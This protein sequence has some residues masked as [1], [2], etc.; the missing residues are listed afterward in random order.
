[1][2]IK[3]FLV[4]IIIPC[5]NSENWIKETIQSA[6]DQTYN[7]KEIIV[8]DDGST[9]NSLE[10]IK[11]F[12]GNINWYSWDN[13]GGCAAR[14]KGFELSKG[15]F[16]QFLDAD[17][18]LDPRKI[19]LQ[20]ETIGQNSKSIATGPYKILG[21]K[22]NYS[23]Q[24]CGNYRPLTTSLSGID[25]LIKKLETG[26]CWATLPHCF[27]TPRVL[28]EEVGPWDETL[29]INQ[30]GE[31]FSRILIEADTVEFVSESIVYY[32]RQN[33]KSVSRGRNIL[34]AQSALKVCDFYRDRLLE[35]RDI[36]LV[37]SALKQEYLRFIH[38]YYPLYPELFDKAISSIHALGCNNLDTFGGPRFQ[39]LCR[40]FGFMNALRIRELLSIQK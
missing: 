36:A 12:E 37:R 19:Q 18:I 40:I 2:K 6:L 20:I 35:K 13:K 32:R 9:D 15:S 14:N 39:I 8:I 33:E 26:S 24:E 29:K 16:I 38:T 34:H 22:G 17:D 5:Y 28:I 21:D 25:W 7:N 31:F 1:M 3:D 27:L 30:D 4:S 10:I 23:I 11:K